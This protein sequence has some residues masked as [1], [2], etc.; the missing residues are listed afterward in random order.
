VQAYTQLT[1]RQ[2]GLATRL[3]AAGKDLVRRARLPAE[4]ASGFAGCPDDFGSALATGARTLS[5]GLDPGGH[6]A[7]RA[8]VGDERYCFPADPGW[9]R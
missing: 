6:D 4:A 5:H 2:G 3:A 1:A 9:P 8:I 7:A